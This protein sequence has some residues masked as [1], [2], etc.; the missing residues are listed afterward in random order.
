MQQDMIQKIKNH[1]SFSELVTKRSRLAW[2]L[3]A[4]MLIIY[5]VFILVI[6][7]DPQILGTPIND[8][9]TTVGIPIGMGIIVIAFALTGIYVGKA[10]KE[11]DELTAR[12]KKDIRR[13]G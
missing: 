7:F 13:E 10:N 11:F 8:G 1:P 4:A 3:S 2:Q 6:A 9:V 12:I 5:Y